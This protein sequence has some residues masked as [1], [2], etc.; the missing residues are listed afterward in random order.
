[1]NLF[2]GVGL[3]LATDR[4]VAKTAFATKIEPILGADFPYAGAHIAC[5]VLVIA[6]GIGMVGLLCVTG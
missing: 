3:A 6:V 4:G 1:M 2:R 5:L